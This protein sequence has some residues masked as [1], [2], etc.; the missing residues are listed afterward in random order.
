M[1][2]YQ[3]KNG[4]DGDKDNASKVT[5]CA[6][7]NSKYFNLRIT[8]EGSLKTHSAEVNFI[9]NTNTA[10][11]RKFSSIALAYKE[12][13]TSGKVTIY[14]DGLKVL[15]QADVGFKLSAMNDIKAAIGR[16]Q[17][18]SYMG[19]GVYDNIRVSDTAVTGDT[20]EV[21]SRYQPYNSFSGTKQGYGGTLGR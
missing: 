16:G 13:E 12:D 21:P 10:K 9:K 14:M 11:D 2:V 5:F 8:G 19:E 20:V 18:T 3:L 17:G 6:G 1:D 4:G 15:D 7:N